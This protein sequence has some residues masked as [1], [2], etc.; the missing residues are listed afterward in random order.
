MSEDRKKALEE[1]SPRVYSTDPDSQFRETVKSVL[2]EGYS[3]S[4]KQRK[5]GNYFS[6]F[7]GGSPFVGSNGV[8]GGSFMNVQRPY[9]PDYESPDRY[10]LPT[11]RLEQNRYWRLFY[12]HDPWFGTAIDLYSQMM[13]SDF[14][15]II[16]NDNDRYVKKILEDM[17]DDINLLGHLQDMVKEYLI[18]GEIFPSLIFSKTKGTWVYMSLLDPDFMEVLDAPFVNMEP[19]LNFIPP[20]KMVHLFSSMDPEAREIQE[21]LPET[22]LNRVRTRQKIR[23]DNDHCSYIPR[24]LHP[25]DERGTSLGTRLWRIWMVEDSVYAS[26]IATFRRAAAPVKVLKLGDPQTGFIPDPTQEA[27][28]QQMLSQAETD[29]QAWL[30]TSYAVQYEAWGNT[31]R[32]VTIKGEYD[33]IEKAKLSALGL[34][35]SF[36]SGE[37][38][39]ASAK[40][41]LQVFLRRL[42][43]MRQFFESV[44]I[45][46]KLFK[47]VVEVNDWI[48]SSP[49]ELRHRYRI[50]RTAS[51]AESE[52]LLL[53][54]KIKWR[55]NLD[56]KVDQDLLQA[57]SQLKNMGFPISETTLGNSVGIDP[58]DE[59][60]KK[61]IEYREKEEILKKTLG[62]TLYN[63]FKQESAPQQVKKPGAPGS[64]AKPIMPQ[65]KPPG[66]AMV[67]RG[68]ESAPPGS[69]DQPDNVPSNESVDSGITDFGLK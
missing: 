18:I 5:Q 45:Y 39:F 51:E 16:E 6:N 2:P 60:K 13:I 19:I 41:G 50:K 56:P 40:S 58:V 34:S 14:D 43:S 53:V 7:M 12:K 32:A 8:G 46:P 63:Q 31:E 59:S 3:L 1:F 49:S 48:K 62:E 57:Y 29:P 35:K 25:Y 30:T 67:P 65:Q 28:L 24:K 69:T 27:R 4:P 61:A 36:M 21:K 55:N 54:P 42:L 44:W 66:S 9:L 37:T 15:V 52:G 64:G 10:F 47:P 38:S 20:E 23:L 17:C 68:T 11:N 22:F 26:T 33:V